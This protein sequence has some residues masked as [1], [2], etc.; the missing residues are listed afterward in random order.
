ML[1]SLQLESHIQR[2]PGR[3]PQGFRRGITM[4]TFLKIFR[5]FPRLNSARNH[6][7]ERMRTRRQLAACRQALAQPVLP[8]G[9]APR[10][11]VPQKGELVLQLTQRNGNMRDRSV[12]VSC[13]VGAVFTCAVFTCAIFVCA[14]FAR[15]VF[16]CTNQYAVKRVAAGI[17]LIRQPA[18]V[19][20]NRLQ[21]L[22]CARKRISCGWF[23]YPR[24]RPRRTF[25]ASRVSC[26]QATR[27][28]RSSRQ[29]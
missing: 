18:Q 5:L 7:K 28:R 17:R 24:V 16:A 10:H 11:L 2:C 8:L 22:R 21:R 19:G 27:A 3:H 12:R 6:L 9:V 1:V 20:G 26:Q 4:L 25:C 29:G 13:L 15:I 23:V 14:I